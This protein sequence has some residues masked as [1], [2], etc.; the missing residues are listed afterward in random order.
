M[1]WQIAYINKSPPHR[2]QR[3]PSKQSLVD[4]L[5]YME[6]M[7]KPFDKND[8]TLASHWC[9]AVS[10]CAPRTVRPSCWALLSMCV[11]WCGSVLLDSVS[12]SFV[13]LHSTYFLLLKFCGISSSHRCYRHRRRRRCHP[14]RSP[15]RHH[16]TMNGIR[17]VANF[18]IIINLEN[19]ERTI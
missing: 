17:Y 15:L 6:K 18:I 11:T 9:W 8:S 10:V 19:N 4:I 7:H 5:P 13:C 1:L 16:R 14:R 2:I 3:L 12:P